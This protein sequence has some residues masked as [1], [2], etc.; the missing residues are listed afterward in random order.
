MRTTTHAYKHVDGLAV[1]LDLY[2]PDAPSDLLPVVVWIHGGALIMGSRTPVPPHL[3]ALAESGQAAVASIDYR[4]APPVTIPAIVED[5][6]DAFR[7]LQ[8]D[9]ARAAGLNSARIA[10]CGASAGGYLTLMSGLVAEPK[11]RALVSYYGYGDVDADWY[12]HPSEHYRRI[13]PRYQR[14]RTLADLR[15]GV[16]TSPPDQA[17][18]D[19]RRRYYHYLRQNGLWTREVTGVEP[20]M[21]S[22]NGT[23]ALDPFCPVRNVTPAYPP[24]MLIHGTADTDVPYDRSVAMARELERHGVQHELVTIPGAEHGLR[25][26][27]ES[28]VEAAHARAVAFLLNHLL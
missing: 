23:P 27:A 16:V 24:T 26:V 10:V 15:P 21:G 18:A 20:S 4:L 2:R 7:W 1:E 25:D 13:L 17:Q 19:A 6:R 12:T 5:L 28:L 22:P 11:P 8:T 3:L 9:D 14:E